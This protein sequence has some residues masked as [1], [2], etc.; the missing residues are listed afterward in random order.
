MPGVARW[1]K[2]RMA[3]LR[4]WA[5]EGKQYPEMARRMSRR[6][7]TPIT[8]KGVA[9]ACQTNGIKVR[10]GAPKKRKGVGR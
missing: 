6:L 10:R 8:V 5:A 4:R 1:T 2:E 9:Y 3:M 7:R